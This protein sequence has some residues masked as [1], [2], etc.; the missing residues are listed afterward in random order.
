MSRITKKI[1]GTIIECLYKSSNVLGS[2]YDTSKNEL[3]I[4]FKNGLKYKYKNVPFEEYTRFEIAESQGK[5]FNM[6]IR[7]NR[8]FEKSEQVDTTRIIA[9]IKQYGG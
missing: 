2:E 6:E 3:A 1:K 8:E 7:K 9:E 4:I 5:Q